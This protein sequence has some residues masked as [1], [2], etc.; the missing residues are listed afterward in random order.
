MARLDQAVEREAFEATGAW[1]FEAI[2]IAREVTCQPTITVETKR[3]ELDL[4]T[5]A[6]N[7]IERYLVSAT[8]TVSRATP[9]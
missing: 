7:L 3:D 6:D 2:R 8:T 5:P 9:S 4:T 1:E